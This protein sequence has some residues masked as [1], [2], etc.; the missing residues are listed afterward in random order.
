MKN[1]LWK[2][3]RLAIH[4]TTF[5]FWGLS[6][7]LLI[8]SYPYYVVFFYTALGLFF[9]CLTGRENH[10]I[11]YSLTL[12][13]RKRDVVRARIVFAVCIEAV[14][15]LIAI[16]FALLRSHMPD[17]RNLAGMDANIALFGIALI[18]LG[19]FNHSFFTRYYRAP[20]KA[21][22]AF[23]ISSI[24][25]FVYILL[26]EASV[27][28]FP[29]FKIRLDTPDPLFLMEKLWTLGIGLAAFALL[30]WHAC[31]KAERSFEAL[32]L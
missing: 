20:E 25:T 21:G 15:M 1:L 12:P 3:L 11:E 27:Q 24:W 10:D 6:A 13:I 5:V 19:L 30:T 31:R 16:P 2:E 4:P 22:K 28:V 23:A 26:A 17:P 32:D 7:M 18:L 29:F 8:P 14:Q 9:V